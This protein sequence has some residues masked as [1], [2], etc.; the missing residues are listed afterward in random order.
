MNIDTLTIRRLYNEDSLNRAIFDH[1]ASRVNNQKETKIDRIE[2]YLNEEGHDATHAQV[3]GFFKAL[4][5]LECGRY[6]T[7]RHG[8]KSRFAW[9]V[10]LTDLGKLAVGETDQ[11]FEPTEE[12]SQIEEEAYYLDHAFVLRPEERIEI[13]LPNDF[14]QEEAKRLSQFILALPFE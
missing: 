8:W 14:T 7:G 2:Y 10:S 9:D 3:V 5:K 1:L 12:E 4:E 13:S 6:V 11:I